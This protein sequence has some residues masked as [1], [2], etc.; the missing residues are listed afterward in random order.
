MYAANMWVLK[1]TEGPE[2]CQP[3]PPNISS[4]VNPSEMKP[5]NLVHYGDISENL[6]QAMSKKKKK[7]EK[8]KGEKQ[9]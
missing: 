4:P 8:R 1:M 9:R 6:D 2:R 3:R 5:V 7:K